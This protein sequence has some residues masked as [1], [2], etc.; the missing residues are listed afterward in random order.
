MA[1]LTNLKIRSKLLLAVLP[2]V[3]MVVVATL[4]SSIESRRIDTRTAS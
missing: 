2:L 3:V 4:Y 1:R